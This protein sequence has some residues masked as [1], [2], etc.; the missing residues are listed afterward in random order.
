VIRANEQ[1]E[2]FD[3][4]ETFAAV[5]KMT[6]TSTFLAVTIIKGSELHHLMNKFI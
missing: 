3:Y 1:V 5:A 4:N 6:S 2:G